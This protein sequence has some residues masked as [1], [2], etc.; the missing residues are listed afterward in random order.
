MG[1]RQNDYDVQTDGPF[2]VSFIASQ[3]HREPKRP[4]IIFLPSVDFGISSL[5][6]Y[7]GDAAHPVTDQRDLSSGHKV[8][9]KFWP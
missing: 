2:F 8:L 4:E 1:K 7:K 6:K 5:C 3:E 9:A